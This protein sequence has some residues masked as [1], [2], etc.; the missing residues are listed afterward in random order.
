MGEICRAVS[1]LAEENPDIEFIWSLHPNPNTRQSI[2][3]FF[4]NVPQ[5]L[6]FK[7]P[8]NYIDAVKL[9]ASSLLIISDSGGIQEEAPTL[10]KRVII[11]R[12]ETERPE[13][14]HCGCGVLVGTNIER[15]KKEFYKELNS[16]NQNTWENPFG[17][18]KAS[19]AIFDRIYTA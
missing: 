16:T 3:S 1:E 12:T 13:A 9:M 18:G 6:I 15:I 4:K 5:N 7:E 8:M 17:N 14:V 10:G 11:L 19:Q 2:F